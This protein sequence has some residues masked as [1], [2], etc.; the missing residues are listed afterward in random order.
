MLLG[1]VP[2]PP[3]QLPLPAEAL[4]RGRSDSLH[5][6]PQLR[7]AERH[8][9]PDPWNLSPLSQNVTAA[10]G[11]WKGPALPPPPLARLIL[12]IVH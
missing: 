5:R 9:L 8:L 10:G 3:N 1:V 6:R 4:P 11:L 12:V 7:E 2:Q